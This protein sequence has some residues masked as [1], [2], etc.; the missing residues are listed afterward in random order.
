MR[1]AS[2]RATDFARTRTSIRARATHALA[3][4]PPF[5]FRAR[6]HWCNTHRHSHPV[7]ILFNEILNEKYRAYCYC[8]FLGLMWISIP[9]MIVL[10]LD[11]Y[12]DVNWGVTFT[13]VWLSLAFTTCLPLC[14]GDADMEDSVGFGAGVIGSTCLLWVTLIIWAVRLDGA[15]VPAYNVLIPMWIM[16]G[17]YALAAVCGCLITTCLMLRD[18]NRREVPIMWGA[19][20]MTVL[21]MAPLITFHIFLALADAGV[22]DASWSQVFTPFYVWLVSA[23][24]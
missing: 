12:I 7:K 23:P 4:T 5:L 13:P 22:L 14:G 17:M 15:D 20:F 19:C 24:W 11:G 6:A 21:A 10:K 1:G 3:C 16:D 8:G 18:G 9:V 2:R